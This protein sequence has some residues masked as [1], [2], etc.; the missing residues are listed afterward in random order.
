[1]VPIGSWYRSISIKAVY[2]IL[3]QHT[4]LIGNRKIVE[5]R[6]LRDNGTLRNKSG[7]IRMSS[8]VLEESMPMLQ[9]TLDKNYAS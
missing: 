6:F 2:Y 1:M 9:N 8:A 5:E 4:S 3:K 7:S